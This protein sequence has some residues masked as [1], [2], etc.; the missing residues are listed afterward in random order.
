MKMTQTGLAAAA[1]TRRRFLTATGAAAALALTGALVDTRSARA[2]PLAK[3]DRRP[4]FTLGVASGDP[5]PD[6]V[7]LWTR[8]APEP[9]APLGG[10][11]QRAVPVQWEVS[12]SEDFRR[13]ARRGTA[14]ARPEY[15]HTVH[16]D[17]RGL[18]PWRHYHYRF[19]AAGQISPVGRTRTA[20]APYAALSSLSLAYASCQAWF[21]GFYTAH[22]DLARR[23]H[24]VVLFLGDYIYEFGLDRGI[25]PGSADPHALREAVTLDEYRERYALY[26]LDPDLQAAHASAP[27]IVA[28]DD[29]EVVNNWADEAHPSAP[30]AQFLVRRANGFRAYWEHMP[31]R[32]TQ[33]PQGPDMRL[34]RR[35]RYGT[36]AEFSM[37]DTRQY[38]SDQAYGDG[39]KP[40]G[41][42]TRDP[43]RTITGDEQERWLLDGLAN[44]RARW[45]VLGQQTAMARLDTL[46]GP[47]VE[48]PMDMWDGYEASRD[49]VLGGAHERGVRN[50][51]ALGGDLHR[52]VA[53]D[54]KL[55]FT[56]PGS[57]TVGAE[58]IGTSIASGMD[59]V[60]QDEAGRTLA[61][62]NPH[63]RFHNFQR[64]Y[65]TC[66]VT[67]REWT[68]DY[69]VADRVTTPGG[70]VTTRTKLVVEDGRPGIQ[71]A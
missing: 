70:T 67:P 65:V 12:E 7:V 29:H 42:E 25:R 3:P 15:A 68:V 61:A 66:T 16:V 24:D 18:R 48:V 57:P 58:F 59:G 39:M 11:D 38:R 49:R 5:L 36:L 46:S 27:W 47:G 22:A 2:T 17:V 60:D 1:A 41:P 71:P 34:Y 28:Y 21:E 13:I 50:L 63:V 44:S 23:D 64:G 45:N 52:S 32:L 51:V 56:D 54:L 4:L 33:L 53:S 26:K 14:Y 35:L 9:L 62:E 8:L 31:L 69:R 20:P 55:D 30:P 6:A 19:R 40:P 37:L 43:A 10:M